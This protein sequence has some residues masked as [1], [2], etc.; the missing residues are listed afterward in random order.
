MRRLIFSD[1]RDF[2]GA[3]I[4][5]CVMMTRRAALAAAA[6]SLVWHGTARAERYPIHALTWVV[7]GAPGTAL[8]V[9]ARRVAGKMAQLLG[10]SV[11]IDN[12]PGAGGTIAAQYAARAAPDGYTLFSGNLATF[13]IAP[14]LTPDLRY[15][16]QR[17]FLPVHGI[18]ASANIVVSGFN[19]PWHSITELVAHARADPG[20][21]TCAVAIGTG[22]HVA[23]A[24][25]AQVAQ[26]ELTLVPYTNFAAALN[27]TAAGRVDFG[28][29][30]P[31]SSLPYIQD[32]RLRA[33]A[34]NA[35]ERLPIT[36]NVPTLAEIGLPGAEVL[37]WTGLYVP[38][39]TPASIIARIAEVAR[40]VLHDRDV[41]V[42][43]ESTGT[44]LWSEVDAGR[45]SALLAGEIPRMR[46]LIGQGGALGRAQP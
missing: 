8:D 12:R 39:R 13:A 10:Q 17:D 9:T 27:D 7:P 46:L 45:L 43:F 24:L 38:A 33:L 34:V 16:P 36:P 25:F 30:Y 5:T 2:C 41:K 11:L 4:I 14:M 37:G 21:V 26:V 6:A 15:D 28:F 44:I 32:G 31:L 19:R 18:G 20:K 3:E 29:D 35:G 42:L 1:A 22:S 23:A 40:E